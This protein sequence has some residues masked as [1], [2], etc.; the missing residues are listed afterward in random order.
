ML[1]RTMDRNLGVESIH[2]NK[3]K[4][5]LDATNNYASFLQKVS[6]ECETKAKMKLEQTDNHHRMI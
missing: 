2:L 6:K 1:K 4:A 5:H 3:K